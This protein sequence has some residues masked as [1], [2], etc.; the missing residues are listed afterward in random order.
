MLVG[1]KF[2]EAQ[3]ARDGTLLVCLASFLVVTPFFYSQSPLAAL[4]ALPAL[5]LVGA[6]L[7][8]LAQPPR[9]AGAA[10]VARGAARSGVLMLQGIPLAAL[11]FLLFPRLAVPLWGLP[12]DTMAQTG[13]SDPM[14]PG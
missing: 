10:R 4:A 11:L 2:L 1:I 3:S 7:E 5:L 8:V 14:A 13:L 9:R 12:S 6:T